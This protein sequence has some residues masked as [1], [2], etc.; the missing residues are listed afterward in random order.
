[1][2]KPARLL[3]VIAGRV[4]NSK[5]FLNLTGKRYMLCMGDSHTLVFRYI[6]KYKLMPGMR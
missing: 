5:L 4:L 6:N 2:I 3:R 1:M